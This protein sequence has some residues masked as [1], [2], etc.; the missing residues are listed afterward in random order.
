V[1][2]RAVAPF[3]LAALAFP[4]TAWTWDRP[5]HRLVHEK[6]VLTLPPPLRDLF[7]GNVEYL[8]AHA[9]DP[10]LW[11]LAGHEEERVNHFLDLDRFGESPIDGLPRDEREH[12]RRHGPEAAEKGR[13]PWRVGEAYRDL[14]AAF[15]AG[16]EALA[17]E[18]A[19]VLGHYV[20]DAHVPL[21]AVANY[22]GQQTGQTGL[23]SRWEREL[24]ARFERQISAAVTPGAARRV[25]DPVELAFSALSESL[26]QA[27]QTLEAD[28]ASTGEGDFI[29]TPEDDRYDDGYYSR[30]FELEGPHLVSRLTAAAE[31]A[32]SLWLSAWE[33]AGRPELRWGFRFPY[34]RGRSRLIVALLEGAG[35]T[36][37]DEAASRGLLPHIAALRSE[38][39][40]GRILPP[41]PARRAAAQA[42]LWTGAEPTRHGIVGDGTAPPSGAVTDTAEGG[43]A[44]A[45]GAEPLWLTAAREGL[46]AVVLG[47]P[48]AAPY[49]A[50]G[51]DR[52]FG[53]DF[54]RG[55]I[56]VDPVVLAPARV[57][58][59]G[60]LDVRPAGE[61]TGGKGQA[62][63][64]EFDLELAGRRFIGLLRDDPADPAVGFDTVSLGSSR[65]LTRA[66]HL[67]PG[68]QEGD[69]GFAALRI[70]TPEGPAFVDLRLFA[71]AGDGSRFLLYASPVTRLA[72]NQ[73]R[74]AAAATAVEGLP[75]SGGADAYAEGA[76][77]PRL[78][79]GGD[80]TA[81]RR[82]L[83]TARHVAR[84]R[85]RLVA[86]LVGRTRWSLL[87][88]SLPFPAEAL[89][90]WAG[91]L[92]P[93]LRG[94]D[95]E[96]AGRLRP[97]ADEALS[98]VDEWV[99]EL[100]RLVPPEAALAL[101]GDRGLGGVDRLVRPNVA[102]ERAGLLATR[103]DGSIDLA[104]TLIVYAPANAGTL[105]VNRVS[106][107][108]GRQPP[109]GEPLVLARAIGALRALSDPLSGRPLVEVLV[110]RSG[111]RAPAGG[112]LELR[113]APGVALSAET[114][115]PAVEPISPSADAFDPTPA[116]ARSLLLLA[117]AGVAP[118]ERLGEVRATDVAPT[119]AALLG[120]GPPAQSEGRPL[121]RALAR[122]LG[123]GSESSR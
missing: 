36:L 39:A 2:S 19:A 20:A 97:L 70:E 3:L 96:L 33:E 68:R 121:E 78:W 53:G 108:G 90:L 35:A 119:L 26:R 44:L 86:L 76:L 69:E 122:G 115:G 94:Y 54:S 32:G 101:V 13:L 77:G 59:A 79:E 104:R 17:L 111:R 91:R 41:Q 63:G 34:V 7:A 93:A 110:P 14:V 16:N 64:R 29:E 85:A 31:A 42:S 47:V 57:Y 46:T 30:L 21:H 52:R 45:L 62:G 40:W 4:A 66:V 10:D 11:I 118:G 8:Q 58:T 61:W 84:Q 74:V 25:G 116:S 43:S 37:V 99:G 65:D 49:A 98:L 38:G 12:R 73:D 117:G 28:R 50:F 75:P 123:S 95:P 23:H 106:R 51:R 81:E 89:R 107:P 48:Q 27:P 22:D 100:A 80:G 6:A 83:E 56:L 88:A 109:K 55:L 92:D 113:P 112:E 103:E 18:R 105:L 24:V 120:L 60:D 9:T 5:A 114:R 72:G 15:R 1:A 102:L 82:Y 71:L 67:K 87:V